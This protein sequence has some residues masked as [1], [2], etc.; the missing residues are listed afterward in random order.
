MLVESIVALSLVVIGL[1]GIIALISRS[2]S[3]NSN[4]INR[5]VA[6]ALA[7]EGIEVVKNIIDSNFAT[8]GANWN[9]GFSDAFYEI[10][11]IC[12]TPNSPPA[13]C[14]SIGGADES[15]MPDSAFNHTRYLKRGSDGAYGYD[16]ITGLA[17][18][19]H[20]SGSLE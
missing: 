5:F 2:V 20:L 13:S 1:L 17:K 7:A 4:V 9:N 18:R 12:A 15:N 10:S 8:K 6:S 3:L 11:F 16:E 19:R 14:R